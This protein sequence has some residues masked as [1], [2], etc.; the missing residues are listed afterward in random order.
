MYESI[1]HKGTF[2]NERNNLVSSTNFLAWK[3]R[4]DLTLTKYGVREYVLDEVTE[5][6]KDK[7]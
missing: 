4:N 7:M 5:S 2:Y 1:A 3:K 6:S